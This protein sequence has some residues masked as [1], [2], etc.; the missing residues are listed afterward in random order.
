MVDVPLSSAGRARK[1]ALRS[2][3]LRQVNVRRRWRRGMQSGAA[4]A[5]L[6]LAT[7][8]WLGVGAR[9]VAPSQ[10]PVARMPQDELVEL[11]IVRDDPS[12]VRRLAAAAGPPIVE[13]LRDETLLA[14]LHTTGREAGM[15]R[16]GGRLVV[17]GFEP[18]SWR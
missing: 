2:Q 9:E 4:A 14:M 5:A 3:L 7:W 8:A 18:D 15:V 12:I 11:L 6:A 13:V 17:A 10:A 16:M 1:A